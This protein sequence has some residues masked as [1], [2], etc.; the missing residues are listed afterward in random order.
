MFETNLPD[1]DLSSV[2]VS[3]FNHPLAYVVEPRPSGSEP[4]IPL[5][6]GRDSMLA[7]CF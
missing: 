4:Y 7:S 2:I 5:P 3:S 6:D 1:H